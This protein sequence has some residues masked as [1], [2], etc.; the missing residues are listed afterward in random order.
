[1]KRIF[2]H[3]KEYGDIYEKKRGG[4]YVNVSSFRLIIAENVLTACLPEKP[5]RKVKK[6]RVFWK[7][8][9]GNSSLRCKTL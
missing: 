8:I 3:E 7:N 2:V 1:M 9:I 4:A 6:K 5:S